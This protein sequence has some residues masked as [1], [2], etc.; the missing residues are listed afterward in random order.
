MDTEVQR[1][2][3]HFEVKAEGPNGSKVVFPLVKRRSLIGRG[4]ACDIVL[5]FPDI[6]SI[7]AV[8]EVT[9]K[10]EIKVY[11][12]NSK[13]G[14][15]VSGER[16]VVAQVKLDQELF[17][18]DNRVVVTNF[19]AA[20]LPAAPL[21]TITPNLPP[22]A[23]EEV[24]GNEVV[25]PFVK[26]PLEKDKKAE[27]SSY[28][29]EDADHLYPIFKYDVSRSAVEIIIVFNDRIQSV[30]YIPDIDG[31]YSLVGNTPKNNQLSYPYLGNGEVVPFIN[32][33]NK[34][35]EVMPI[36]GYELQS[37]TDKKMEG[38]SSFYL[39]DDEIIQFSKQHIQIFVRRTEAPPKVAAAPV[40]RRD[41]ELKKYMFLMLFLVLS[42]LVPFSLFEVN[43]EVEEEKAPERI[44][45]ILYKRK[46]TLSKSKAIDKTKD[47]PKKVQKSPKLTKSK[48]KDKPKEKKITKKVEK[49]KA[50]KNK[51]VK[52]AKKSGKVRKASPNKGPRNVKVDK[53]SA[54]RPKT[55]RAARGAG[56]P[57]RAAKASANSK[58]TVDTYKSVDFKSTVSSLLTKGGSTRAAKVAADSSS[59][60]RGSSVSQATNG[61]TIKT[62]QVTNNTGS[63]SGV[64]EGT[65]DQS[66]GVEGLV[67]KKSIYTAGLP[68]K[69]VILGGLDPDVIRRILV[70]NIPLFRHCYQQ[71][72]DAS[73]RAFNGIVKLNFI[74]GASG[75]VTKAGVSGNNNLPSKVKGCVVNVLRRITFPEPMGGGVVEVG[76]PMNFYPKMK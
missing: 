63:L 48:P 29:F 36:P 7:H 17:L 18:G 5:P 73:K 22:R 64:T 2:K 76:Q 16:V 20:D 13:N 54:T 30:D 4:Q 50:V 47:A 51:G 71:E 58:G 75:H 43:E 11:D 37:L 35:T 57:T 49:P 8:I 14:T 39:N 3:I 68:F 70:E 55:A 33:K 15:K 42:F 56:R 45:T 38:T 41:P 25:I 23:P 31:T 53:V 65:L 12:L 66:R 21:E 59:G 61:A 74:I 46:L 67:N 10:N 34:S 52:T 19:K 60:I 27:F 69:T 6:S 44:A 28:I 9:S 26:Y 40:L 32:V 24:V 62:A 1:E 72:L